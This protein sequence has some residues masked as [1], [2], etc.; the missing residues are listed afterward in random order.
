MLILKKVLLPGIQSDI[1]QHLLVF[2]Q[3][4]PA[5][6]N[7]FVEKRCGGSSALMAMVVILDVVVVIFYCCSE[8]AINLIFTTFV[9]Q[10]LNCINQNIALK[11][12]NS[13]NPQF[14]EGSL[15]RERKFPK[16]FFLSWL[17]LLVS[18]ADMLSNKFIYI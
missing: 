10:I 13:G 2:Q 11:H 5:N 8:R 3:I 7:N 9:N 1:Y 4:T 12:V 16:S 17:V 18:S 6:Y 14:P 15:D